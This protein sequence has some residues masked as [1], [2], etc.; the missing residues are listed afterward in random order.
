MERIDFNCMVETLITANWNS[1]IGRHVENFFCN[2]NVAKE[3]NLFPEEFIRQFIEKEEKESFTLNIKKGQLF[4]FSKD[5]IISIPKGQFLPPRTYRNKQ[6]LLGRFYPS[7]F[8]TALSG[9]FSPKIKPVRIIAIKEDS[10]EILIDTNVPL[11]KYDI[12]LD[13]TIEKITRNLTDTR[14]EC[15]NW[16]SILLESGPGMQVRSDGTE[17]DFEFES[18]EGFQRED[19]SDDSIF[20]RKP[21]LT[22]HIDSRCNENLLELYRKI[23]PPKGTFL[24][25]MSS[26]QSHI[27]DNRNYYVVGLGLNA[28]EMNKNQ[29]LGEYIVHDLNKNPQLPFGDEEF[30]AVVCDLSIEYVVKP[31]YLISQI[32]RVLKTNGVV[33]FSFSNRYFP[34]K[35]I[36]VWVD[37]HEFERLGYV[38]ELLLRSG[39]FYNFQTFSYRGYSRPKDDKYFGYT[40]LSDPLYVVYAVKQ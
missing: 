33:T 18:F 31:F 22:A 37:L 39:G 12:A 15:K 17:T 7:S 21:R 36:K 35:V 34:Q 5:N 6:P 11:S 19:E 2:I 23:L 29:R 8:F 32:K 40:F 30:D 24:D 10:S 14:G 9:V 4:N 38:L 16:L 26:Y 3:L 28:E 1:S 13:V 27:P 25:L 20:Y